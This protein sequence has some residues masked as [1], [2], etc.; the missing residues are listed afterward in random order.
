MLVNEILL[1]K[2]R[3]REDICEVLDEGD[4]QGVVG[5]IEG[6]GQVK[7]RKR[8]EPLQIQVR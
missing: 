7:K 6:G 5:R 1:W 2:S 8:K 3:M 4:G